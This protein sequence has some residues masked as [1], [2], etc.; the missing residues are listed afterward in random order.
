MDSSRSGGREGDKVICVGEDIPTLSVSV[1]AGTMANWYDSNID[2]NL[3]IGNSLSYTPDE[4]GVGTYI[5][6]VEAQ[7]IEFPDCVSQRI[8]V[9]LVI[10][11]NPTAADASLSI[12]DDDIDGIATFDLSFTI[13]DL[14]QTVSQ[15]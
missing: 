2:G 6:Y 10:N 1:E 15:H 9:T 7:S 12:C 8:E 11:P 14:L 3:L 4:N 5:F 13:L